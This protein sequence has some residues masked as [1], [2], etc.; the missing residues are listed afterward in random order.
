MASDLPLA[1]S[2]S[3]LH[4]G[5]TQRRNDGEVGGRQNP[6]DPVTLGFA[7]LNARF[8]KMDRR[9]DNLER[10]PITHDS[11]EAEFDEGDQEW[12]EY[13]KQDRN[14]REGHDRPYRHQARG[15]GRPNR[16]GRGD[17]LIDGF[18]QGRGGRPM[19]RR[20]EY[21]SGR[22]RDNWDPPQ[23]HDEWDDEG[24]DDRT[25]TC[26]DPPQRRDRLNRQGSEY[27]PGMKMD[28]PHFDGSDAPNWISRVQY[29]FDHKRIPEAER[30][31]YVVMLFD[32]PASEWIFN[33]RETNGFVTWPEFLIDVR[34]RFDPQSFKNYTGLIAKL[35]QTTTVADYH[36]TFERY[37]NRVT[38]LSESALIP[39]FIQGLKQPLQ[40]KVELQYPDSLAEAMALA[41]RLAATHEDRPPTSS[42]SCRQWPGREQR[43]STVPMANQ[44]PAPQ[45]QDP[46]GREPDKSRPYP[47]RVSNAE[48]S[49]RARR[50]LCYHCPEK[51][52]T[53][54]VCKVKL[55]C[56]MDDEVE[57]PQTDKAGEPTSEDELITADLSHLHA[58]DGRGSSKPFIVPGTVGETAV[59]VLIDTGATLDFLHPR[60]AEALQLDLSP[61]RPFRVL[62]GNGE[63]LP[64]THISRGTK[65]TIQ[66]T[67]FLVDL[68]I[69]AH[70][71]PDVILGM[72]WLESLG[73]V[74]ADFVKKTLEFTHGGRTIFLQGLMPG[75][76]QISLHSLYALTA[77]LADNEFYEIVPIDSTPKEGGAAGQESFPPDLPSA[78]MEVL[79]A[80]KAVFDQPRGIPPPRPFDHRIHLLPGTRP[81][82]V[83]PYR[84]PYFQKTEIE[85]Q[86]RDMLEQGIIRH[87]H[88]PFSSPVLLIRKKDGTFRFCI[89][90]RALNTATVPD[91]FPI[92][93]AE[94]LFDELGDA[95]YFSKLDLRSGYHQIRMSEGDIFKTA[96]RTHDGHFEFL[97]MP[98]GLTNAPSTFQAAMNKIFQPLLRQCVIVFFDDI[99]IYS[100]T[101]ELH[102]QHL[103]AV[104][105][106]LHKN[107]FFVKLSKCS[108]CSI[109]VE[110][111]GHII[112]D[113][114]LK[115]D[116]SKLNAMTAWPTPRTVKQLRGFLGLTGYYRRFVAHYAMIAAP[117][118]DLLK[119]EAFRW[120]AEAETA[121]AALKTA[122]A[123]APVLQLPDFTL[124][125]CVETD[126]CEVGIGA[127]L[128]QRNHPVAFFS[129][130][131]GPRRKIASTY[132]KELYA[133]AEA[134]QKWR[135]YLLGREFI[136]RTDQ[137]SLKELLQQVVQTP[138]QQLYVRK[139]MGYK[140]VIEYKRGI[141]NKAAD[142]LSRQHDA[143]GTQADDNPS[144]AADVVEMSAEGPA[145]VD[146]LLVAVSKPVP[147][148]MRAL[149]HETAS[150][151]ELVELVTKIKSGDAPPH[152][153]WAD[154]LPKT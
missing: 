100:P 80:H 139:L 128:M 111:L 79:S 117:L 44:P 113:G 7:Q 151:P 101:L 88:S 68:H 38:D 150:R 104:L 29:F 114:Q 10:R 125:F 99:L 3:A 70:H 20:G 25:V 55:L 57:E 51:W 47:I 152:L 74:S 9:V 52:V 132:H 141:T 43:P 19:Q 27:S 34:H 6:T 54:H 17:R 93:T 135:Q 14:P 149:Q 30:L 53:G 8:D 45:P 145:A 92:P 1:E 89:D 28:A 67:L 5:P 129:K 26:W 59:R 60:I 69:L 105:E 127:I 56:Y 138:D 13:R 62:V 106:L 18:N 96:F 116:P 24:Y 15:R 42:Y 144:S 146:Q 75:P 147:D 121:F 126:A 140:F 103:E 102:G 21:T 119:K 81:V 49:E 110:Y 66:G 109:T 118:T 94:E 63:S 120:S 130:K 83:R 64:C 137:R 82:N 71:E 73:K 95:K 98:F 48:R 115:A 61:I 84:Y 131:L 33:Y 11:P 58:L 41:L 31:H 65:L 76:K 153:S 91:H 108:F 39:I 50:G 90:Y 123:S 122:M 142:A 78:I 86:V 112:A 124:P 97:V 12:E 2:T 46:Q 16:G 77:Q 35:V 4:L 23:R 22:R 154:G 107:N 72:N 148:I 36:A 40:E 37:L 136:I 87:S 32:P 133:I 143:E 85:K 134:V